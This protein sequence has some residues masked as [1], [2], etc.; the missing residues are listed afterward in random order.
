MK[1]VY[2]QPDNI[3]G[4]ASQQASFLSCPVL[5]NSVWL[6]KYCL[7][8]NF[9]LHVVVHVSFNLLDLILWYYRSPDPMKVL[10]DCME[11]NIELSEAD[12]K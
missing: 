4:R 6:F 7:L 12:K 9:F 1:G 10:N 5:V 3:L 11:S 8:S 2:S